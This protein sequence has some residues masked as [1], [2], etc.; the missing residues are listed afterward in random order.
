M[1]NK[2]Q[3]RPFVEMVAPAPWTLTGDGYVLVYRLPRVFAAE[4][5][6]DVANKGG[7]GVMMLVDYH[8]SDV[9]PYREILFSPGRLAHVGRTGYSI[10]RIYVDSVPS[11]LNGQ[12]NWGIPKEFAEFEVQ[13]LGRGMERIQVFRDQRRFVDITLRASGLRV[14][15]NAALLPPIVQRRDNRTFITRLRAGGMAQLGRVVSFAVDDVDLFPPLHRLRPL[16]VT[17]VSG[18]R[19]T[20]PIPE[21]V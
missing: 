19:M 10:S 9:G 12:D 5:S 2:M 20:F 6:G 17:R 16:L 14:P 3:V 8:T 18:F 1:N 21:T 7:L 15:V 11:V 4:H 13:R